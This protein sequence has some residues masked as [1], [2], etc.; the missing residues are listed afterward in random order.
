M[1]QLI[2]FIACRVLPQGGETSKDTTDLILL[3]NS[4]IPKET[5]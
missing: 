1:N 5:R 2:P 3:L 4:L